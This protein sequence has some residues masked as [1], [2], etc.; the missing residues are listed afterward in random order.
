MISTCLDLTLDCNPQEVNKAAKVLEG[1]LEEL[2]SVIGQ[3]QCDTLLL[4][5]RPSKLDVVHDLLMNNVPISPDG[6]IRLGGY[7][8]GNWYPFTDRLAMI[9]DPKTHCRSGRNHSAFG[10]SGSIASVSIGHDPDATCKQ[11]GALCRC[12]GNQRK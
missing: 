11:H 1:V 3:Y 4:T 10:A 6:V 12:D 8:I 7:R 2:S 5:G 9:R